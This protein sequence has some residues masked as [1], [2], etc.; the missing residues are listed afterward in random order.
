[1]NGCVLAGGALLLTVA[2]D[3]S[4]VV[5][6]GEGLRAAY[7]GAKIAGHVALDVGEHAL[8]HAGKDAVEHRCGLAQP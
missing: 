6:V 8:A 3:V 7:V 2:M 4:M 1:V 5:G